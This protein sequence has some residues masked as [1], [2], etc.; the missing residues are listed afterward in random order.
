M[1]SPV[2]LPSAPLISRPAPQT[3]SVLS[4]S[5][6][7]AVNFLPIF[8]LEVKLALAVVFCAVAVPFQS[9]PASCLCAPN[10]APLTKS[11]T[12]NDKVVLPT[13]L[14]AA[15]MDSPVSCPSALLANLE[16]PLTASDLNL[17][18][19]PP[20]SAVPILAL[21]VNVAL[22]L[23]FFAVAVAIQAAPASCL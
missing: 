4:A 9:A 18:I 2:S 17:F 10:L 6:L 19:A 7:L 15:A 12:L 20:V 11:F 16:A 8:A 22:A 3:A 14:P 23:V 5:T 13:L 21:E 1:D